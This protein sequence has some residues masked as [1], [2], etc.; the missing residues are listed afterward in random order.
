MNDVVH[1][2]FKRART[3]TLIIREASQIRFHRWVVLRLI[4]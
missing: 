2:T 1:M 4:P 3:V